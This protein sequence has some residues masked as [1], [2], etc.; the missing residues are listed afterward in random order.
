VSEMTRR[1]HVKA[2]ENTKLFFTLPSDKVQ[3]TFMLIACLQLAIR[4]EIFGSNGFMVEAI[5]KRKDL[6]DIVAKLKKAGATKIHTI[7]LE[8]FFDD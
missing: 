5:V 2:S 4:H 7:A 3:Q 8:M 6:E 1:A